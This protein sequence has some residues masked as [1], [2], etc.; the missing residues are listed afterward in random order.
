MQIPEWI[1]KKSVSELPGHLFTTIK[2]LLDLKKKKLVSENIAVK[3]NEV[4]HTLF[5]S[6]LTQGWICYGCSETS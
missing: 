4:M 5:K 1:F 3:L 6:S 2:F